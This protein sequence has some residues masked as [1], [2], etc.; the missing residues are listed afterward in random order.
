[1]AGQD[2]KVSDGSSHVL[3]VLLVVV[4]ALSAPSRWWSVPGIDRRLCISR[5]YDLGGL[6]WGPVSASRA[7]RPI[8]PAY[9]GPLGGRSEVRFVRLPCF[10][11]RPWDA[12]VHAIRLM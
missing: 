7:C 11:P 3:G 12:C 1:M 9:V 10:L 4:V 6:V 2:N 8:T 5:L